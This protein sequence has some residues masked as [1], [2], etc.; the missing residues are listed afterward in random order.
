[1]SMARILTT[2]LL[3]AACVLTAGAQRKVTPVKNDE[4]KPPVPRLHYYDKHGQ[5]LEKPVL[6]LSELDTV[7]KAKPGPVYPVINGISVGANFFDGVMKIAGQKY[8]SYDVWADISL[9][10][11]VFPTVEIGLGS[12]L[13][14]PDFSNFTYKGNLSPYFKIGFNYNFLYKSSPDYQ[15]YAGFRVGF[16]SFKYE[17]ND[18]T[19]NNSFWQQNEKFN[20]P[21]QSASAVW[22]EFLLG[23]KVKI[24]G[25][26]SL[27]WTAR[28]HT[29]FKH[30]KGEYGDPWFIPGYGANSPVSGTF[31]VIF[32]IP[33]KKGKSR[34]ILENDSTLLPVG[35]HPGVSDIPST[36]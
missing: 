24:A 32:T 27:G 7:P 23:L 3:A 35:V 29:K 21:Q 20:F 14:T 25:P 12:A 19:I 15:L 1:M 16:S 18:V 34:A 13:N 8:G 33:L 36:N 11:W 10:N 17:I 5:P 28:F 9:W 4:K 6:F 31:S 30:P 26:F 2:L 22:G